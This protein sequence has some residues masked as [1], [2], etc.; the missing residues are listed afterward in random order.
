MEE[1]S[2]IDGVIATN[3]DPIKVEKFEDY[4]PWAVDDVST[5]L[6]YCCPECDFK[7]VEL[8]VSVMTVMEFYDEYIIL[9]LNEHISF[10]IHEP[11]NSASS[12]QK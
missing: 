8:Q 6:N 1:D 11:I 12:V 10:S 2:G 5:F 7:N 9:S 4:N 3:K